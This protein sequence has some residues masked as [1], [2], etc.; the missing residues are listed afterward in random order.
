MRVWRHVALLGLCLLPYGGSAAGAAPSDEPPEA[1]APPTVLTATASVDR[2]LSA[3]AHHYQIRLAAGQFA[4]VVVAQR[5]VDVGLRLLDPQGS[6]IAEVDDQS[7]GIDGEEILT[8]IANRSG[9][10]TL[11]VRANRPGLLG[12]YG[13]KVVEIRDSHPTDCARIEAERLLLEG[14]RLCDKGVAPSARQAAET[15]VRAAGL[16]RRL[17]DARG[18]MRAISGL[19]QSYVLLGNAPAALGAFNEALASAREAACPQCEAEVLAGLGVCHDQLGRKR[20]AIEFYEESLPLWRASGIRSGQATLLHDLSLVHDNLG[21]KRIALSGYREAL[22]LCRAAKDRTGEAMVLTALGKVADDLGDYQRAL[23][24]YEDALKLATELGNVR[25]QA[26]ILTNIAIVYSRLGAPEKALRFCEQALPLRQRVGDPRGVAATLTA[27]GKAHFEL[28][29]TQDAIDLYERALA[30][31]RGAS[32]LRGEAVALSRLASA[33][34]ATDRLDEAL[35]THGRAAELRKKTEDTLLESGSLVRLGDVEMRLGDLDAA[36]EHLARSLELARGNGDRAQQ[37]DTLTSLGDLARRRGDFESARSTLEQAISLSDETRTRVTS[38]ELRASYSAR[39]RRAHELLVDTL[40]TL[41]ARNPSGSFD[42]LAFDVVEHGRARSLLEIL[43]ASDAQAPAHV[44]EPL[45]ERRRSLRELLA[46]KLDRRIRMASSRASQ[47]DLA[48]ATSEVERLE[49][50]LDR[51]DAHIRASDPAY[52]SLVG[53]KS[54]GLPEL[55]QELLDDDTLLLEYSLG[56]ERGFVWAM[57]KSSVSVREIPSRQRIEEAARDAYK[58]LA[59]HTRAD[60]A[61]KRLADLVLRPV[62]IEVWKKRIVI[63]ADGALQYVPFAALPDPSSGRSLIVNHEEVSLPSASVLSVLRKEGASRRSPSATLAVFADPVFSVDD[64]RVAV[65]QVASRGFSATFPEPSAAAVS[66]SSEGEAR[67]PRLPFT[68]REA[69]RILALVPPSQRKQ[70]LD[71]DASRAAAMAADVGEYRFVHFATHGFLD[72]RSPQLSGLVLSLVD[73][74]GIAQPGLLAAS[75]IFALRLSA[76]LVVLSGCQTA[77]GKDVRGE[78]L[79]G[80]TRAFMYA[81]APRVV[82]SLWKV[83]DVA[84]AELMGRFYS[85]MLGPKKLRPAAALRAAQNALRSE[86][87]WRSPYYWAGFVLQGEWN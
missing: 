12:R 58:R 20:A 6:A 78:G 31:S 1:N 27:M 38:P 60:E 67:L 30:L 41:H 22:S 59:S 75:D 43:S 64:A 9:E 8:V 47:G 36:R 40:M 19:G 52:A 51:V 77:L 21:E 25:G 83:D 81:G 37:T 53:G 13:L 66:S 26:V 79:V 54:P 73:R 63:V 23:D 10:H 2:E 14:S 80:L 74:N 56:S 68:R 55:Q 46:A 71:F 76:D 35:R 62:G 70:A 84:T 5:G 85:A 34:E 18:E 65:A 3:G 50:E 29:Q 17:D 45:F 24:S 49:T 15:Y 61:L 86:P 69:E 32:D 16:W 82:S 4:R 28:H 48:D 39:E 42:R 7:L 72:D 44:D 57:T 33:Y 11:E 87:R